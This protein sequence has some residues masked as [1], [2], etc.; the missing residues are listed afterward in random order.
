MIKLRIAMGAAL[1]GLLSTAAPASAEEPA[2]VT[3]TE[4]K[5]AFTWSR[6]G[7]LDTAAVGEDVWTAGYQGAV[8]VGD[9]FLSFPL[10]NAKPVVQRYSA[11]KWKSFDLPGPVYGSM[12]QLAAGGPENVWV[13]GISYTR[14]G[15][16]LAPYLARWD[17]SAWTRVLLP[18]GV[19][20]HDIAV[21]SDATFVIESSTEKLHTYAD[22]QWTADSR[23]S[24]V[25]NIVS[26]PTGGTWIEAVENDR[27]VAARWAG[28]TWQELPLPDGV[29]SLTELYPLAPGYLL[30]YTDQ[31]RYARWDGSA[32]APVGP[33][34]LAAP[35]ADKAALSPAGTPWLT[36]YYAPA[37]SN[38]T[39]TVS[40]LDGS[41]WATTWNPLPAHSHLKIRGIT[42][43]SGKIWVV[44]HGEK[45]PAVATT[46][47]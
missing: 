47:S 26:H 7:L 4:E 29:A 1:L 15:T 43:T 12:E 40:W 34:D 11:G 25:R 10:V 45:N 23:F 30:A 6:S 9:A 19:A 38:P 14:L 32:W 39:A 46:T 33:A 41:A 2:E 21:A 18:E 27:L 8:S 22:G 3:W 5:P 24:S 20:V 35:Y 28:G 17:G 36:R 31:K 16:D 13:R 44:G 37:L 42:A